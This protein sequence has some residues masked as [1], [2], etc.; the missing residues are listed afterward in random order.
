MGD[1]KKVLIIGGGPAG[2]TAAY[3]LLESTD[4]MPI[5]FEFDSQ[6]GGI[7]KTVNYKGNRMDIGGHRFFSKSDWVMDWWAK[8]L[9]YSAEGSSHAEISYQNKKRDIALSENDGGDDVMLL[10][11]R[12]SRIYFLK[13]FFDYP[14]SLNM[15]TIMNLGLFR[16]MKIGLG[17]L[18]IKIFPVKDLKNLEDFFIS[19]FGD[20]LYRTFFK[21]YTEKVWGV[22]CTEISPEWGAQRIKGLSISEAL[23]HSVRQI[24]NKGSAG[25]DQKGTNTSLIEQFLYPKFGPGQMWECVEKNIKAR[26]AEVLL[27]HEVVKLQAEDGRIVSITVKNNITG[28][29]SNYSGDYIISTMPVRELID[30]IEA[31]KPEAISNIAKGLIYR[32]FMT[33]GVLVSKLKVSQYT[34]DTAINMLPDNWIYIQEPE[35][36]VGRLQIF[37]NWSPHLVADENTVWLGMEYFCDENDDLWSMDEEAFLEFA[38]AELEQIGIVEKSDVIDTTLLKVPKAYPAYF[39]SYDQFDQLQAWTDKIEN[40]FLIGRN[41]M[42][43]YNNQDHSMLT[44][45]LAV[46]CI[47]SGNLDKSAIWDINVDDDY[48][49]ES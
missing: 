4:Y 32:D 22:P 38:V 3:Q 49:E 42:H 6:V 15:N 20:E 24:F 13:K 34:D 19:R 36:R 21:D 41:G 40:L 1:K 9:P 17:Y 28:E 47:A 16:L 31:P 7:S 18:K 35:V 26:G 10:R 33:A 48:H 8:I 44:A 2:L 39:G 45:K 12:L 14:V 37:N 25:I 43:R 27:E 5:V 23:L 46:E 11:P 29:Q 30:A